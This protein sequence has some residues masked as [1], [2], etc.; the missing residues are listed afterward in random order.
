MSESQNFLKERLGLHLLDY[1][2]PEHSNSIKYSLGGMTATSFGVLDQQQ[3]GEFVSS[4][5]NIAEQ[6]LLVAMAAIGL[7]T[8]FSNMYQIGIKPFI[9]GFFAALLVGGI[10]LASIIFFADYV[11][12][13]IGF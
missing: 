13:I 9:L 1:E 10:S 8:L 5:K 4:I 11:I 12:K 2:V 3:W 7:T 6:C